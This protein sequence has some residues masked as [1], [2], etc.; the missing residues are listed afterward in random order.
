MVRLF[1]KLKDSILPEKSFDEKL[2]E[3]MNKLCKTINNTKNF[4]GLNKKEFIQFKQNTIN[5]RYFDYIKNIESIL[6]SKHDELNIN[7]AINRRKSHDMILGRVS[8]NIFKNYLNMGKTGNLMFG[9]K[10]THK[11]KADAMILK[12]DLKI[13]LEL[14]QHRRDLSYGFDQL[15]CASEYNFA[16]GG[17]LVHNEKYI[18][19]LKEQIENIKTIQIKFCP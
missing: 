10:G 5:F 9:P 11:K 19:N 14:K 7:T 3:E 6:I 15:I 12:E 17:L 1:K 18:A 13:V 16:H 4:N 8:A 2:E